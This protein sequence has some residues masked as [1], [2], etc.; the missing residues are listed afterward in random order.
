[1]YNGVYSNSFPVKYGV[2]QGAVI[3]SVLFCIY[4]GNL[5]CELDGNG[6]GCFIGKM[7]VG[8]LAHAD[9]VMLIEPASRAIRH[10]HTVY[11]CHSFADNLLILFN[12]KTSNFL[13]SEPT[14]KA[15]SFINQKSVFF[16][17][18]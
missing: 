5:L 6:I 9:D 1:M 11:T 17:R 4:I 14:R 8:A 15:G 18:R 2:K 7:F 12:A 16:H 10:I 3:N 13:I